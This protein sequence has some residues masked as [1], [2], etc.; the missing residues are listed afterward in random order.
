MICTHTGSDKALQYITY[1]SSTP[2][3]TQL[4]SQ[5]HLLSIKE[6]N[7]CENSAIAF[8]IPIKVGELF[9]QVL[10]GAV[11]SSVTTKDMGF[12][13]HYMNL[14]TFEL[15]ETSFQAQEN[16]LDN[17]VKTMNELGLKGIKLTQN[18]YDE[19][20]EKQQAENI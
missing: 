3:F 16:E 15:E 17:V 5:K 20:L 1:N 2:I 18:T 14:K 12:S 11:Q 6:L 19:M 10:R 8:F 13:I 9:I 4:E 7:D